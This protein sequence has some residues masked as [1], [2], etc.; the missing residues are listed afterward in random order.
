MNTWSKYKNF[1]FTSLVFTG[2]KEIRIVV[3]KNTQKSFFCFDDILS[4]LNYAT[5]EDGS[6]QDRTIKM[7]SKHFK[8]INFVELYPTL[9]FIPVEKMRE[10][11][12]AVH[13]I[14]GWSKNTVSILISKCIN[15]FIECFKNRQEIEISS[16]IESFLTVGKH[17]LSVATF[18]NKT[19]VKATDVMR[20]CGYKDASVKDN[21]REF[22]IKIK[23]KNGVANFIYLESFILLSSKMSNPVYSKKLINLHKKITEILPKTTSNVMLN[24]EKSVIVV[25]TTVIPFVIEDGVFNFQAAAIQKICG[26][27]RDGLLDNFKKFSNK[28]ENI[29]Y[30]NI[31]GINELLTTRMEK[32]YKSALLNICQILTKSTPKTV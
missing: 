25:D 5:S 6:V 9:S 28:F 1:L 31:K 18:E 10:I 15:A 26:Y 3:D 7:Y 30:L 12:N 11:A 14:A 32:D 8:L 16:E 24:K 21:H 2:N 17:F 13:K 23:T 22:S 29:H 19:V 27:K 4:N 20:F